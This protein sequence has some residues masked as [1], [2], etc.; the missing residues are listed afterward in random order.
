MAFRPLKFDDG[1]TLELLMGSSVTLTKY[2]HC[3]MTSGYLAAG[4]A[5]DNEVEYIALETKTNSGSAGAASA[6]VLKVDETMEFEA[7]SQDT[8]VQA[9]HVGN[10][11]DFQSAAQID[12]DATTDKVFHI[13]SIVNAS[14][15]L[16]KGHFN[17]PALA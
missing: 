5:G 2:N 9:T 16:V 6:L 17:K 7:L 10:D 3:K 15:K 1:K 13:D 8:P 12:L 11:Y 4:A 14:D